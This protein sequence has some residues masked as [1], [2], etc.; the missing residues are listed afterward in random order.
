MS[1]CIADR[2]YREWQLNGGGNQFVGTHRGVAVGSDTVMRPFGRRAGGILTGISQCVTYTGGLG[3]VNRQF[4]DDIG[5]F[6]D[7]AVDGVSDAAAAGLDL[8][9][10]VIDGALA[11]IA[12]GSN[13]LLDVVVADGGEVEGGTVEDAEVVPKITVEEKKE[14]QLEVAREK[15]DDPE[16]YKEKVQEAVE[17]KEAAVD[18]ASEFGMPQDLIEAFQRAQALIEL[19]RG[20]DIADV[21]IISKSAAEISQEGQAEVA[22]LASNSTSELKSLKVSEDSPLTVATL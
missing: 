4:L 3:T 16:G 22:A 1:F 20:V 9:K 5:N 8:A 21:E 15:I 14:L 11:A 6:V 18:A 10:E 13:V 7:S 19:K 12:E 2:I 17:K